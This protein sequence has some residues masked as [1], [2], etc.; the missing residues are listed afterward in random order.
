MTT[1]PMWDALVKWIN[2]NFF[3]YFEAVRTVL[4]LQVL[5][6]VKQAMLALPWA[7]A[8]LI[9]AYAGWRLRDRNLALLCGLLIAFIAAVGL[10][11]KAMTTVYLCAISAFISCLIG[12]PLGVI[13]TRSAWFDRCSAWW[14]TRCRPCPPSS[15]S[16]RW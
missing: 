5:N 16:S 10:W 1:A 14:S 9:A 2:I 3:D 13:A 7:G 15:I 12:I 4:L 6:P 8:V 11:D